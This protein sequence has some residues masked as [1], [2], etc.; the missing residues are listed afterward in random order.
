MR[1]LLS[2]RSDAT[3]SLD[4]T[5]G[6][7]MSDTA[8]SRRKDDGSLPQACRPISTLPIHTLLGNAAATKTQMD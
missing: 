4:A 2:V 3:L 8:L 6:A 5:D 1:A 7:S